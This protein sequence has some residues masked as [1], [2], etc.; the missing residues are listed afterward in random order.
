MRRSVATSAGS[1]LQLVDE[2]GHRAAGE[3]GGAVGRDL[4]VLPV[5]LAELA[6]VLFL[7]ALAQRFK[8]RKVRMGL[9]A[10]ATVPTAYAIVTVATYPRS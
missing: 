9:F 6:T 7:I 1:R 5:L 8:V 4:A 2:L 3:A 10:V